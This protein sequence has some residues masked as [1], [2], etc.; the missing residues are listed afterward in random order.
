MNKLRK[1]LDLILNFYLKFIK[2]EERKSKIIT[3]F[4]RLLYDKNNSIVYDKE[5]KIFWLKS[6]DTYLYAVKKPYF[7]YSKQRLFNY[8][9]NLCCVFYIP[10]ENDVIVDLGA[11]IGTEIVYFNEKTKNKSSIY[12]IEANPNSCNLIE[13]LCN[14]NDFK[15]CKIFNIGISDQNGKMWIDDGEEYQLNQL[16]N[17]KNGFEV[18]IKTM[19]D[20]VFENNIKKIDFLKVNIEGAELQ[21]IHGMKNSIQYVHNVAISCHDFLYKNHNNEIKNSIIKFLVENNF[22]IKTRNTNNIIL[23]SWIFGTRK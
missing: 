13:K 12:C 3:N 14:K 20:F 22:E 11:G 2:T 21:M 10:K 19:D 8:I 5:A 6:K 15:N 16:N 9:D 23:N 4:S 1:I 7:N 18:N 17:S